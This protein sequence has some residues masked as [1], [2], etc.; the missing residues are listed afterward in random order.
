[1]A[2][3][4]MELQVGDT[5]V[6][7]EPNEND[8]WVIGGFLGTIIDILDSGAAIV[9]DQGS[10]CWSVQLSRLKHVDEVD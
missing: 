7:P 8:P 3:E 1:V 5:V 2:E 10:D 9:E 6:M 4:K